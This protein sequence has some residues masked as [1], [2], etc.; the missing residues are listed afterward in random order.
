MGARTPEEVKRELESERE[1]LGDAVKTLRS[2]GESIVRKLPVVALGAAGTGLVVRALGRRVFHR[3][4]KGRDK[5][6]RLPFF[7]GD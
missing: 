6:G 3:G 1:R 7:D 4:A 2:Q 5:R